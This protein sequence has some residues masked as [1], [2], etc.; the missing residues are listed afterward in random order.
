[1]IT[2][3]D[4]NR[5]NQI[6]IINKLLKL[7]KNTVKK[8]EYFDNFKFTQS[9]LKKILERKFLGEKHKKILYRFYL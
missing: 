3:S 8:S 9:T 6:S 1:M 5:Q 4:N 7:K 2:N